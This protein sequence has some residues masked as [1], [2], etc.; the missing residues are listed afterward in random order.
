[1]AVNDLLRATVYDWFLNVNKCICLFVQTFQ[2]RCILDTI[3]VKWSTFLY[4]LTL[5]NDT[6]YIKAIELVYRYLL[7]KHFGIMYLA[8]FVITIAS[9]LNSWFLWKQ[10]HSWRILLQMRPVTTE[11]V[12]AIKTSACSIVKHAS[13]CKAKKYRMQMNCWDL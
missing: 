13:D 6:E 9:Y 12:I 4:R 3:L 2:V 11:H 10:I 7:F 8:P 1:M 5:W